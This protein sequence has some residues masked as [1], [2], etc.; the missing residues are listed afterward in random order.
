MLLKKFK[1]ITPS[2]RNCILLKNKNLRKSPLLKSEITGF[3]KL[4]GKNN[5]GQIS[6]YHKGGGHKTNYRKINFFRNINSTGI[7]L[8]LEYDPFRNSNIASIFDKKASKYFYIIA[9]KNLSVGDVV[10]SS[11][12]NIEPKLGHSL[13]ISKIPAGTFLYNIAKNKKKRGEICRSAGTFATLIEIT[14]HYSRIKLKSDAYL[15]IP[16][17]AYANIGAVSNEKHF[18]TK[19]GKAG[20]N[21]WLNIRPT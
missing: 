19:K 8:S 3:N 9:P 16:N 13:P 1:P 6:V 21:R 5:L 12:T 4:S 14:K 17:D 20:R 7:V 15:F 11:S 18:L 10:K 2:L